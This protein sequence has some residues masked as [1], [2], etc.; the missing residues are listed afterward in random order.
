[1]AKWFERYTA[2]DVLVTGAYRTLSALEEKLGIPAGQPV[3]NVALGTGFDVGYLV[4]NDD[5]NLAASAIQL[6]GLKPTAQDEPTTAVGRQLRSMLLAYITS[7]PFYR[8]LM[9]H[10]QCL[11]APSQAHVD[12]IIEMLSSRGIPHMTEIDNVYIGLVEEDGRIRYD[13]TVDAG[14]MLEFAKSENVGYP[15]LLRPPKLPDEP[16]IATVAKGTLVRPTDAD[17]VGGKR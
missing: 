16:E 12:E 9:S 4:L 10:V 3:R 13:P 15:G 7:Q 8:P 14:V 1:M 11:G 5:L 2:P 6:L 17:P